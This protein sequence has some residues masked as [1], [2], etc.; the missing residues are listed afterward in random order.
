MKENVFYWI[1]VFILAAI[2]L[3]ILASC[4]A[5]AG[6]TH[7]ASCSPTVAEEKGEYRSTKAA[8][9]NVRM[10]GDL[11]MTS[12]LSIPLHKIPSR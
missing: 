2:L 10:A 4:T 7:C 1:R 3:S 11:R 6:S 8:G 9:F 12:P 5:W